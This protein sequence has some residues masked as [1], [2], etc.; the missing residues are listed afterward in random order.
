[1]K[2]W[3]AF[4]AAMLMLACATASADGADLSYERAVAMAQYMRELATGDYLDIKQV[5]DNQQ[6]V[7]Y[8]WAQAVTDAPRMVV[9]LDINEVSD[10]LD[11]RAY[12]LQEPDVVSYEAQSSTMAMV[13]QY[14]AYY[15]S[16]E[17]GLTEAS[18]E[19]IME[20][21]GCINAMQMYAEDGAQGNAMYIV[22]YDGAAP[23]VLLVNAENGAVSIQGLF[24]PSTRLSKCQNYGQV[25][26][27]LMM[28]GFSMTC[29]ELVPE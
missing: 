5:P 13:W 7:A 17:A 6:T 26:L 25:S 19:E 20:V 16:Q 14:L 3:M 27:W 15:A 22:F 11:T 8:A 10:M 28:N 2:K 29:S 1:M 23:I 12:F 9:Q 4:L 18:Y 24:L 21:N